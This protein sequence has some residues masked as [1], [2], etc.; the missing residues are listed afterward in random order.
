MTRTH[1]VLLGAIVLA[2]CAPAPPPPP[3]VKAITASIEA[4]NKTFLA[5]LQKGDAAAA[6]NNYQDDA[7]VMMPNTPAWK[8][9]AAITEGLKGFLAEASI[10]GGASTTTD[11]V[12]AG[13]YA[14]ETGTGEWTITPK[15]GKAM[16][17]KLKYLTTWHKQADGS[18]K[19]TRDIN[20]SDLPAAP[21]PK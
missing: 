13:D 8:G 6:A 9:K 16:T 4:A 2:A 14:I 1:L 17:D 12:V 15:N 3:D 10:T 20:N 5:N 19:I 7:I 18:W 21:P 11:V